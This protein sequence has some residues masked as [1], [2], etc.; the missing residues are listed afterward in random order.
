MRNGQSAVSGDPDG[1]PSVGKLVE[2]KKDALKHRVWYKTLNRIER[3][4]ID[5]TV[6]YVDCIKS[7]KL[8]KVVTA[9]I[10]K[11]QLTMESIAEKLVRTVGLPLARKISNIAVSWGNRL[12]KL[13]AEDR[14]FARFLVMNF[15]KTSWFGG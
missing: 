10:E 12:A 7:T 5:L 2:I 8:A 14:A 15:A 9:I 4:I 11:L 1:V 3:G 6:K 13:W